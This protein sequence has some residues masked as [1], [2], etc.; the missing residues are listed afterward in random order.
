[1]KKLLLTFAALMSLSTVQTQAQTILEEDF[2]TGATASQ[3]SPIA[4]GEGWTTVNS[5]SG[6]N[7][8]YNWFNEYRD[9]TGQAGPTISGAG[10]ASCDAPITGN[11]G[12]GP[13]EEILLTPELNLN[14]TY[15]LQFTW[16][17]SPMNSNDNSKYD[18]QVRVVEEGGNPATAETVFSIQNEQMLR[19]S[20]VTVFPIT[21]WDR[22]TS[23][24]DLS[25]WKNKKVKIAF[26]FK[27]L[28][29]IANIVWLDD[30]SV[31][32][33]TPAT[34]PVASVNFSSYN[35]GQVYMGEKMFSEVIT[36]TNTGKDGLK[37]TGF[38][39][40]NGVSTNLDVNTINLRKYD[41]VNFNLI[42]EAS[43]SSAAS[44]NAIIHTNGGDVS[45]AIQAQKQFLPDGYTLENF[46][47]EYFPPAGWKNNG[48]SKTPSAI[49]GE[50]SAYC[51]GGYSASTLCS[52]KLDLS[53]GGSITFT[54]YNQYDGEQ[55]Y[56]D[57][58][59]YV[60]VSTDGRETW[61][62]KWV[63]QYDPEHLNKILTETV[64]LG[65]GTDESYVR[66][67]YPSIST[68]EEEE[69]PELSY[70][71]LDRV[72]LPNVVGADGVPQ[73]ATIVAPAL[74]AENI[75]PKDIELKWGPAQFADG[76]KVYVGTSDNC[77]EIVN[78]VDVGNALSYTLASAPYEAVIKWKV[79]AYNAKGD[80]AASV[81]R[82][83][84]Q[85]DASILEFPYEENFDECN[86]DMPVPNGWLSTT[87]NQYAF[88]AWS[89]NSIYP[90]GGSGVSLATGW[91]SAGN[92]SVLVSPE[93][94]LPAEGKSMTIS[95]VWGDEHPA[96]LMIDE[97]GLLEKQNV[98][99]GNGDSDVVFEIC[100]N[101]GNW[102][103]LS[104]LSENHV[105]GFDGKKYWRNESIDLDA[106]KGQRVQFRWINH[107]Y[108]SRHD[109]AALDN[110]VINGTIEDGVVFNKGEW[111]A[112]KVNYNKS[113]NSGAL[114]TMRNTGKNKLT[115][116]AVKFN[117]ENFE[118]DIQ[119]GREIA[120]KEGI[121]FSITF[122]AKTA[123]Q[124]VNDVMTIEFEGTDYKAEFP[125]SGEALPEDMLYYGFEYNLLDYFWQKDF[126]LNDV[127]GR[128]T[129]E[130]GYYQTI[131]ENDGG[132]YA[133]TSC[134]HHN[135]LLKAHTGN[136]T[137][138]A[139]SNV[140]GSADDWIVSR[141]VIPA[142]GAT[143][144]FYARNL[145]T[146]NTV[147]IGDNDLH[148]VEVLVSETGYDNT[149]YF[150]TVMQ[151]V[152]MSYL[153]ENEWHHFTVDLSAYVDKP[154]Y[155]AV[156]HTTTTA[157]NL[158]LFDDFTYNH[159][160]LGVDPNVPYS[161]IEKVA[162][163]GDT[164]VTVYTINGQQV[165]SGRAADVMNSLSRGMF[166]VKTAN[167][168]T[169]KMMRK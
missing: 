160:A 98:E 153:G 103:Q 33:F 114:L 43:T 27:M 44:G 55:G 28:K 169:M 100:A 143:F 164:H 38:T 158:A 130:L 101:G 104:Y 61:T 95:F 6:S 86:K 132:R 48:W 125:V 52:P 41:K 7:Y 135:D 46:N 161:A 16:V 21:T 80:G 72:L 26:V 147:F 128:Q 15:E 30:V 83:T 4:K 117:T 111:N 34:G 81:W 112:E 126:F 22:H 8:R 93:F 152:E 123:A 145:G 78:G 29:S 116:K 124:V 119:V 75:Y 31:K 24:I 89:P 141:Q 76:Y 148:T 45:I 18:L 168:K 99:G 113:C 70:F 120:A 50:Y 79:V 84:T 155:I 17:V 49:E 9:P 36:L 3:A 105:E 47:G 136:R 157:N 32:K 156:R 159:V 53:S 1:M 57:Y 19:E 149:S 109:G 96:D 35:F 131:V 167:G 140:E 154:I 73:K 133:F 11:D 118:S 134:E 92:Q 137:I 56:P 163:T 106:Y 60:E 64:D 10:C 39:M 66:F 40:P 67:V 71:H 51:G 162:I 127:D 138:V 110:I 150:T 5:Y 85:A 42:Y 82:F 59:V 91:M 37:A 102:E 142:A 14:D 69:Y 90:Y 129:K 146:T 121:A 151:P 88:A 13:R 20:G 108:S 25:D 2:E 94:V 68:G 58:D 87:T 97:T 12:A 65:I 107:S 166:I 115:V 165:G 74:G 139:S 62:Q 54:Y 122:N 77:N 144:D 63:S 23:K